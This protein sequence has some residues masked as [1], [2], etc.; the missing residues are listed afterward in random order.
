M[1][2]AEETGA[3]IAILPYSQVVGQ[4]DLKL[5]LELNHIA[6][7][8]R[9]V[10]LAGA[11]GTAK[12]TVVRA[13]SLMV[14]GRLPV[15]LTIDATD[16]RVLGGWELGDLLEGRTTR[17]R[18]LLENA[19][20]DGLLY[21]D[22]VNL[23]NDHVVN[24]IL[25][26]ASTGVL[27]VQREGIDT[28][29]KVNF[30]LIGTMNPEEGG[31]RPQLLDRFG[32]MAVATELDDTQ[33]RA[34]LHAVLRFDEE[35]AHPGGTD[36]SVARWRAQDAEVRE[37]LRAA[38]ERLYAVQVPD[39]VEALA[40]A[41]GRELRTVGHRGEVVMVQAARAYAALQGDTAVTARHLRTVAP[42]ALRHR[43]AES[44]Q[45]GPVDW[46][47]EDDDVLERLL[48]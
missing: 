30:G 46:S 47:A 17:K 48:S 19:G 12:S 22:E 13:F 20:D 26:V 7:S 40:V 2:A 23:L 24:I 14:Q 29:R 36:G 33:R 21:V 9:G 43:K 35:H 44:A 38:R 3:G 11:P 27:S 25:D 1:T 28:V 8:I 6:P 31:L 37:R 32:L 39:A 5:A 41:V 45:G 34:M 15:T 16:D 18:G 4:H 42:F 10:L